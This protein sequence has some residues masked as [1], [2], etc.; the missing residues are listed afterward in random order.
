MGWIDEMRAWPQRKK[1]NF[2]W[3]VTGTAIV[4]MVIIWI[5]VGNYHVNGA[6]SATSTIGSIINNIKNGNNGAGK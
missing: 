6:P 5:I 1:M 3:A 4:I 2:V